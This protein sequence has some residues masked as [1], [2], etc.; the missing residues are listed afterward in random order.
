MWPG[1]QFQAFF[2]F[3]IILCKM[4]SEEVSMLILINFDS[5]AITYLRRLLKKIHFSV[6]VVVNS[7]QTQKGLELVFRLYFLQNFLMKLF[8][9]EHDINWPNYINR[10]CLLPKLFSKIYFW[11]YAQAFDDVIKFEHLKYQSL[12]FSRT[13]RAFEVK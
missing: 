6:E 2:N 5:S 3:Q 7:L 13:K 1:N 4:E 11:F 10:P 9:L 12:I 8:L